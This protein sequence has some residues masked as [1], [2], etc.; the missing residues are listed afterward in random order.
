MTY[1]VLL[2]DGS[3]VELVQ[4][5]GHEHLL[6]EPSRFET[7]ILL[8]PINRRIQVYKYA[9]RDF[10]AMGAA[11]RRL[12]EAN[13]FGKIWIKAP[14]ADRAALEAVGF[15]CEARFP[16]Y[17]DGSDAASMAM[18]PSAERRVR[19][20]LAEE[21]DILK[22]ALSGPVPQG[23]KPLPAGYSTHI[24]RDGDAEELAAVYDAVFPT[25][26]YPIADPAYLRET[27][28]SHIVYRVI[29]NAEDRIV[30]AASAETNPELRNS[31][32]TDFAALESERGKGLA[33]ILLPMLER[34]A[35]ERFGIRHFYT[36]ARA[37]SFGMLRT[38]HNGG[39]RLTGTLVNNCSIAGQFETM[40][41]LAKF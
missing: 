8:S 3:A 22:G 33:Q 32:M 20:R 26:P 34:D 28:A 21:D 17:F 36:I 37:L 40:H 35:A 5:Y 27:A 18:F 19:P 14:V 13:G 39:Y 10:A 38:F 31:E 15:E 12:A 24:F 6:E 25:Y 2:E 11:L 23:E 1:R 7:K 41:V 4:P 16:G 9:A 30:A 29:R